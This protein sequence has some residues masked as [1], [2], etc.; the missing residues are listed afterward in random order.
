MALQIAPIK[1]SRRKILPNLNKAAYTEKSRRT[2]QVGAKRSRLVNPQVARKIAGQRTR[3]QL[4]RGGYGEG[5]QIDYRRGSKLKEGIGYRLNFT[6]EITECKLFELCMC[7]KNSRG[8]N[9][10]LD[11]CR[12]NNRQ[13]N[14]QRAF[15]YTGDILYCHYSFHNKPPREKVYYCYN[16]FFAICQV[17]D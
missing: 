17:A 16:T 5:V 2:Q 3:R 4:E 1:A 15:T 14:G 12:R 11:T 6:R 13:G 10:R 7:R 8:E 9:S